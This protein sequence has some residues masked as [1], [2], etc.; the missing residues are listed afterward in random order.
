MTRLV[1]R[2]R[3]KH[4]CA[5]SSA[6]FG[7]FLDSFLETVARQADAAGLYGVVKAFSHAKTLGQ[8]FT[9]GAELTR[10]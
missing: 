3:E 9:A 10:E 2:I 6:W 5:R 8:R 1:H 7:S 4:G